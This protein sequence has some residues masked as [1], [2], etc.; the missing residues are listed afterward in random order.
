[1]SHAPRR[2]G[3]RDSLNGDRYIFLETLL[4]AQERLIIT[5]SG[6]DSFDGSPIPPSSLVDQFS[7]HLNREYR[8]AG[9]APAG[10]AVQINYPLHPFSSRYR[11]AKESALR[12]W[13]K[14]WFELPAARPERKPMFQWVVGKEPSENQ[15]EVGGDVNG[16][17]IVLSLGDPIGSFLERGCR[18]RPPNDEEIPKDRELFESKTLD[19]WKLR[20]ALFREILCDEK[21]AVEKLAAQSGIPPGSPGVSAIAVARRT[22]EGRIE[23][24][25]S[26]EQSPRFENHRI[27]VMVDGRHFR[28]EIKNC[29]RK[30]S[31]AI[32]FDAGKTNGKRRLRFWVTH[33]FLNLEKPVETNIV[34]LD[35]TIRL[36]SLSQAEAVR[37]IVNLDAL[38]KKTLGRLL[39][40][41]PDVSWTFVAPGKDNVRDMNSSRKNAWNELARLLGLGYGHDYLRDG[42]FVDA[43]GQVAN[44]EEAMSEI[45][46]GEE[47][48]G[49]MAKEVFGPYLTY[50]EEKA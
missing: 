48:F 21:D 43:F 4:A 41:I 29:A 5:W 15:A 24:I 3:D 13:N 26:I 7:A 18:I 23:R 11:L 27:S 50:C 36:R 10:D 16:N 17:A 30:E 12:T 31:A 34:A 9:D 32:V 25:K 35:T 45:P 44:W 6:F 2:I 20:D 37:H 19:D 1:M 28:M 38:S 42:R 49:T 47:A 46:G 22:V 40:F 14:S 39:P 8:L 33:L